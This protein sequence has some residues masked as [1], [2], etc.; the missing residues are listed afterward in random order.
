MNNKI[1]KN[2]NEVESILWDEN[3]EFKVIDSTY[4]FHGVDHDNWEF[5]AIIQS[6]YTQKYYSM[7]WF[8]NYACNM[9][10]RFDDNDEFE[11]IEVLPKEIITII[12]E[13][14]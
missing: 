12:Y 9:H 1:I 3:P 14:A 7:R 11:L 8:D 6:E 2:V 5:E 13:K 10:E 4:K